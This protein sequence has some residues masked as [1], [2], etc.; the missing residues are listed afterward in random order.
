M[1][2]TTHNPLS[3][4]DI[5]SFFESEKCARV[6]TYM[7]VILC[8]S[9]CVLGYTRRPCPRDD[10][11]QP[12]RFFKKS[13][14]DDDDDDYDESR[15][16]FCT[17]FAAVGKRRIVVNGLVFSFLL[18]LSFSFYACLSLSSSLSLDNCQRT[19]TTGRP[20]SRVVVGAQRGVFFF[21]EHFHF[22]PDQHYW[23]LL[24]R[25]CS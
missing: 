24:V 10:R 16:Y 21:R 2:D 22:S 4:R 1:T 13:C 12:R 3:S 19:F 15:E 6:Y 5:S 11:R 17:R 14:D 7:S 8:V 23:L 9:S 25:F 20:R 18:F